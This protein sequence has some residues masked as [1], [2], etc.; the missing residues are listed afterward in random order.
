[1]S[2]FSRIAL[3]SLAAPMVLALAA[4]GSKEDNGEVAEA[5]KIDPIA[6][7]AGKNWTDMAQ[8]T[9]EGGILEGN[10]DAPIKLVEY[11]SHTCPHCAEF[12]E[13]A[14]P[15][16][17][18]KYVASGRVSYEM[19]NQIHDPI[20]LT[21]AVLARCAGPEAFGPLAEQGWE[22]LRGFYDKA[23][24]NQAG[25]N[26]AMEKAGAERFDGIAEVTGLFDFFAA[27]GIS[28]DQAKQCL[29]NVDLAKQI[30]ER[31]DKQSAELNVQGTPTF[32]INGK[33]VGTLSWPELEAML[34]RAGAR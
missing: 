26:A 34:Q 30:A 27:R 8:E 17:T 10:P 28:K 12:N 15:D 5:A 32:F 33:N 2:L 18:Q 1:M 6:P 24:G 25:F 20:D 23:Q 7:P 22:D 31:S 4:C 11:F 19:R 14:E 16:L 21:F 29:A 13:A 3:A 9:P